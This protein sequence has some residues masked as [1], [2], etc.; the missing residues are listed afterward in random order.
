MEPEFE[1]LKRANAALE[2]WVHDLLSENQELRRRLAVVGVRPEE[3]RVIPGL[4]RA[5]LPPAA[6]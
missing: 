4:E 2:A 3:P 6:A 5:P 1:R